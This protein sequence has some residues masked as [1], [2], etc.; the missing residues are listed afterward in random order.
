MD[1]LAKKHEEYKAIDFE[2]RIYKEKK[3]QR[4]EVEHKKYIQ[5]Q[6]IWGVVLITTSILLF[7]LHQEGMVV[8]FCVM[9]GVMPWIPEQRRR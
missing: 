6:R 7:P 4:Y 1:S 3:K 8:V 5:N 2:L 9:L